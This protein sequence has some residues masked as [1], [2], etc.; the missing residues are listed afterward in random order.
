MQRISSAVVALLAIFLLTA[1]PAGAI[2]NGTA[3]YDVN[4]PYVGIIEG[5][6]ICSGSLISPTVLLTAGHCTAGMGTVW[7]TFVPEIYSFD[8]I[9]IPGTAYTHPNYCLGCSPGQGGTAVYDVG[10]VVFDEPIIVDRYASLPSEGQVNALANG[11][12]LMAVGYG[13]QE[14][15]RGGGPPL[16][17]GLGVRAYAPVSFINNNHNTADMFLKLSSIAGQGGGGICSG[18]S[19]GP[20]LSGDTVLGVTSFSNWNCNSSSYAQ[21]I[22]IPA[23]LNFIAD[24][25]N[26]PGV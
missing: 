26:Y 25:A 22:D 20:I 18:D 9:T 16:G 2:T 7:V 6:G 23:V 3:D 8:E 5:S 17:A 4:Y 14:F 1:A 24:P 11:S 15:Q 19:G 21:R 10:V 13:V 12:G